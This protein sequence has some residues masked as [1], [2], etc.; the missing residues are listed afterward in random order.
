MQDS[1]KNIEAKKCHL[2]SNSFCMNYRFMKYAFYALFMVTLGSSC[3]D[4][5]MHNQHPVRSAAVGK[6]GCVPRG[7]FK[8]DTSN[9]FVHR[10]GS[11]IEFGE[12][13]FH[14]RGSTDTVHY[15]KLS[16]N[17]NLAVVNTFNS[18]LD[19]LRRTVSFNENLLGV[20]ICSNQIKNTFVFGLGRDYFDAGALIY[21]RRVVYAM[22]ASCY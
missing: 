11:H 1:N 21:D 22:D 12:S 15:Q 6:N 5:G 13:F 14:L 4:K 19:S 3:S 9:R 7:S 16:L 17:C 8:F 20:G 2:F 18:K 10:N